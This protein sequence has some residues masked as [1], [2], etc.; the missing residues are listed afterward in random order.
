MDDAAP[1]PANS[2]RLTP[3]DLLLAV[4]I[5]LF[6]FIATAP[7][8][9]W[10]EFSSGSENLVVATT[11]ELLRPNELPTSNTNVIDSTWLLPTLQGQPRIAKPP[12]AT[13][14]AAFFL[15]EQSVQAI[16]SPD[17]AVRDAAYADLTWQ[18][19]WPA[20]AGACLT[21]VFTY[22]FA[23][24]TG[25]RRVA[26]IAALVHGATYAFLRYSRLATTDVQL[27]L[28]V[29]AANAALALSLLRGRHWIGL[30]L[31]GLFLGVAFLAKGP[32]ALIQSVLPVILFLA[33]RRSA[34]SAAQSENKVRPDVRPYV[35][36]SAPI[37][38][39]LL[40][41]A[42]IA[43]PWFIFVARRYD[44]AELWLRE[45][46][47]VGA[48]DLE[49]D[50]PFSYLKLFILVF[51]W[52]IFF[53]GGV[54]LSIKSFS[55]RT[56][57]ETPVRHRD[58][59][60]L[61]LFLLVVPILIMTFS[62]DRKERYLLPMMAPAAILV[63]H[64]LADH[65]RNW[66]RSND[67]L[68]TA[69]VMI[70]WALLAGAGIAFPIAGAANVGNLLRT[71]DNAPWFTWALA[72]SVAAATA[73]WLALTILNHQRRPEALIAGTIG[74]MLVVQVLFA[75]GY[76]RAA[77][78]FSEMRPLATHVR[79]LY[80]AAPAFSLRPG[81]RAP[82]DLAIYLNRTV[83]PIDSLDALP[84]LA[85]PKLLFLFQDR[86]DILPAVPP[87]ATHLGE[88]RRGSRTWHAYALPPD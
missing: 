60:R 79:D 68:A 2:S 21:L 63:A 44:V 29:T 32:V 36:S 47:R 39:G 35:R 3:S 22:L 40:L 59:L 88:V 50:S 49:P 34:L 58:G 69:G 31:A 42:A 41:F 53:I 38:V 61:C 86:G 55:S 72:I 83:R 71:A 6:Y 73:C 74:V 7:T 20:L 18:F 66:R 43:A 81:R 1:M 16:R 82:E 23:H 33:I 10:M 87:G 14:I 78:A 46:T 65:L 4:G 56:T 26:I 57:D 67:A 85:R 24:A 11:L 80:P 12:L 27:A 9:R 37:G 52:P 28:W 8:L 75:W 30:P 76:R 64:A 51:P 54:I 5:A 13:W 19:R 45:V 70:H 77:E 84:P 62:K 15:N 17:R 25:G 48:T